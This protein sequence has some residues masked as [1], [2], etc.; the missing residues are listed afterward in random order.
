MLFFYTHDRKYIVKTL[1]KSEIPLMTKLLPALQK[2]YDKT[3][4]TE[5]KSKDPVSLLPKYI[6]TVI[7]RPHLTHMY[8]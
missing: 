5:V 7:M 1:K 3:V 4:T 2:H 8:L 6:G